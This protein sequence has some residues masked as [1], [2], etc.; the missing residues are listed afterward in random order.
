MWVE[1]KDIYF[2]TSPASCSISLTP[3]SC[4]SLVSKVE[5]AGRLQLVKRVDEGTA[6]GRRGGLGNFGRRKRILQ[7]TSFSE[8]QVQHDQRMLQLLESNLMHVSTIKKLIGASLVAQWLG[9]CL[10]M[11]GTR[12]RA[13]VWED[14]TCRGAAG[15]V[16]HSC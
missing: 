15:P 12:V 6:V 7:I 11:Q 10:L 16:S 8:P 9:V 14:P 3:F 4:S 2:T 1:G 5:S 13:L